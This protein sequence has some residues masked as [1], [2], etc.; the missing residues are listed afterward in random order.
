MRCVLSLCFLLLIIAGLTET[1]IPPKPAC[2]SQ[3]TKRQVDKVLSQKD[4]SPKLRECKDLMRLASTDEIRLLK[5]H[6]NLGISL[7]S[8]W[9]EARLTIFKARPRDRESVLPKA[10]DHILRLFQQR[11]GMAPPEWWAEGFRNLKVYDETRISTPAAKAKYPYHKTGLE[12]VAPVNLT[13]TE[14][15]AN[16]VVKMGQESLT[17]PAVVLE[18][19]KQREWLCGISACVDRDNWYIAVYSSIHPSSARILCVEKK[20]AELLWTGISWGEG[21]VGYEGGGFFHVLEA[22]VSGERVLVFGGGL[23]NLYVQGLRKAD[24]TEQ[25]YFS[26]RIW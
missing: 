5:S 15:G 25:F 13:V 6:W 9:Q 18:D 16:A 21:I 26:T 4:F 2:L 20:S 3:R 12:L 11:L 1:L 7:P 24:G 19:A 22:S 8:A 10:A 17:L 23:S 14:L